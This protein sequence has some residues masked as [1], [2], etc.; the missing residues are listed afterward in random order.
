MDPQGLCC[1]ALTTRCKP[2]RSLCVQFFAPPSTPCLWLALGFGLPA[3][4]THG[5]WT[6][7]FR[8]HRATFTAHAPARHGASV[9]KLH[10][11]SAGHCNRG[12]SAGSPLFLSR[13]LHA[14][15]FQL[16]L[17]VWTDHP[18]F[19]ASGRGLL[20]LLRLGVAKSAFS[21][22][23]V[24]QDIAIV[25]FC[26]TLH[27]LSLVVPGFWS[28]GASYPGRLDYR[29]SCASGYVYCP[30]SGS[31]CRECRT[32][33]CR[34]LAAR[35]QRPRQRGISILNSRR[36]LFRTDE[37]FRIAGAGEISIRD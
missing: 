25:D 2:W 7:E 5:G 33:F 14:P 13:S 32:L 1:I 34:Y 15:G 20:T 23:L 35:V 31:A 6:T 28:A 24:L 26:P 22:W 27:S 37:F 16:F 10:H 18:S 17:P 3:L 9:A 36:Q 4:R 19:T 11:S 29:V 12:L 21:T 30:C 8:A